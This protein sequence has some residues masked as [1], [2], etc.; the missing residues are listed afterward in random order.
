MKSISLRMPVETVA[1]VYIDRDI[2]AEL[3]LEDHID[4]FDKSDLPTL[5]KEGDLFYALAEYVEKQVN[6]SLLATDFYFEEAT[7][8]MFFNFKE[9]CVENF[10]EDC[11]E[12]VA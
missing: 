2:L 10:T 7:T 1:Y 8:Q 12:E 4:A 11:V 3:G 9:D 6:V 5:L